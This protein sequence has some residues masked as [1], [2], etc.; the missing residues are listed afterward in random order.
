[1]GRA[2]FSSEYIYIPINKLVQ[3][4]E[5]GEG[6]N[7]VSHARSLSTWKEKDCNAGSK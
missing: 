7:C 4:E 3:G 5:R 1:M 2:M 6:G